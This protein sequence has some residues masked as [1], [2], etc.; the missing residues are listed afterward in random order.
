[1]NRPPHVPLSYNPRSPHMVRV[2]K[3]F[4][5]LRWVQDQDCHLSGNQSSVSEV[6]E[7][8]IVLVE[9]ETI[10]EL[11]LNAHPFHSP[12]PPIM[13]KSPA[14]KGIKVSQ[15]YVIKFVKSSHSYHW[16]E[17]AGERDAH[18]CKWRDWL[19][20]NEELDRGICSFYFARGVPKLW[21]SL[22]FKQAATFLSDRRE[23]GCAPWV[24]WEVNEDKDGTLAELKELFRVLGGDVRVIS[25]GAITVA[26]AGGLQEMINILDQECPNLTGVSITYIRHPDD[27]FTL[28]AGLSKTR[29]LNLQSLPLLRISAERV[30]RLGSQDVIIT[31]KNS[32]DAKYLKA[33][34]K[35][36]ADLKL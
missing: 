11:D 22:T 2:L 9:L 34:Q 4:S 28:K 20:R 30:Y 21:A 24:Q 19:L 6:V 1:M 29:V 27:S 18:L 12:Q 7:G 13:P 5:G 33:W 10:V 31:D 26:T 35:Q 25:I 36:I 8:K 17:E 3:R 16:D 14:W 32:G 23:R 15:A